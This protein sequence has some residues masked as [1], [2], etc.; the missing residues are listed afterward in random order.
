MGGE[1]CHRHW[2][3]INK[4][5]LP[6]QGSMVLQGERMGF[7]CASPGEFATAFSFFVQAGE[8]KP[9]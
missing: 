3:K 4:R 8:S 7:P 9:R 6:L 1:W 5:P 2:H